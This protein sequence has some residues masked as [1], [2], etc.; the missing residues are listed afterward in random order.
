M[1]DLEQIIELCTG[2][3][4]IFLRVLRAND[5]DGVAGSCLHASILL[6]QSLDKFGGCKTVVRGGDGHLDGGAA[7]P[8]G[9]CF[10]HYWVEGLSGN[11]IPFVADITADQFGWP[12]VVVLPAA[13]AREWYRPGNDD[14][15]GAAV[16]EALENMA[17][18]FSGI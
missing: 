10:G 9:N 2:M 15:A 12:S 18:S 4:E 3:R 8:S 17:G 11:G 7:D 13:Q 5:V 16:D 6:S 1:E 14:D